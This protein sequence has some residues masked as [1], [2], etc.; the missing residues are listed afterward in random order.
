MTKTQI[1]SWIIK[2]YPDSAFTYN[3]KKYLEDTDMTENIDVLDIVNFFAQDVLGLCVCGD[4]EITYKVLKAILEAQ[5]TFHNDL[6]SLANMSANER[7]YLMSANEMRNI[8]LGNLCNT[9]MENENYYGLI[10]F[11]W[12]ILDNKGFL[13]H[14][15]SIGGAWLTEQGK[16][17]LYALQEWESKS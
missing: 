16:M 4:T 1:A 15:S 2:Y 8:E 14:G 11:V 17:F 6:D 9:S 7:K 12:Y 10:Q 5:E 3:N 13:E